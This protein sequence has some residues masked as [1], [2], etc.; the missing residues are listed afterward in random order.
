MASRSTS[1]IVPAYLSA[2]SRASAAISGVSTGS[3][4]TTRSKVASLPV[5]SLT[6]TRSSR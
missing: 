5:W 1:A 2:T 4:D 3:G 6:A